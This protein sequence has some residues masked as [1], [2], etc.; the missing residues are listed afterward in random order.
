MIRRS[1][2]DRRRGVGRRI[3]RDRRRS[4]EATLPERRG[5]IERRRTRAWGAAADRRSGADRRRC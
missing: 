5:G 3:V 4:E 2:V 1:I